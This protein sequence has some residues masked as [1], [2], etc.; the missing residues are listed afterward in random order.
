MEKKKILFVYHK[1]YRPGGIARVLTNLANALADDYDVTIL[2]LLKNETSFY[3]LNSKIKV[4]S[5]NSYNH[6]AFTIGC[7]GINKY[8]KWLPK[9]NNIK[10]YL[11]DFGAHQTLI[12]WMNKNHQDYDSIISCQYKLSISLAMD[13][14]LSKKTIAWEHTDHQV[15]GKLYNQLRI[16][17]YINLN[18]IV[19]INQPS[20]KY[21][22]KLNNNTH[23]FYNIIGKPFESSVYS[24]NKKDQ[25]VFVGRL[26]KEKNVIDILE[27][28]K[29]IDFIDWE[30]HIIGDGPE[31]MNLEHYIQSHLNNKKIIFHRTQ[32]ADFIKNQLNDSKIFVFTSLKEALPTVLIEA[33]FCGNAL[34]SYDCEFGP[35]DIINENNGYLI[36]LKDKEKFQ[37]K[38][39]YL[40]QNSKVL[41]NLNKS[42]YKEAEKW[43]MDKIVNQWKEILN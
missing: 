37:D 1:L 6:P 5:E 13:K 36:P 27:I 8:F 42:S 10:N 32:N 12:K 23:L 33:M 34:I 14:K 9:K 38:L 30:F 3:K 18:H 31:R 15:G 24:E 40:I 19:T 21:Y 26:V 4:I 16:K 11:Y 20:F 22:E 2:V 39:S 7:V 25:I 17:N 29:E 43:T 35:S 28:L 41:E